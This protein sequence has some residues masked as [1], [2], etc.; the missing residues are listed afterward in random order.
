LNFKDFLNIANKMYNNKYKYIQPSTD[1]VYKNKDITIICPMH[2]EYKKRVNRH[3]AG[4]ACNECRINNDRVTTNQFI[5]KAEQIH[6]DKYDYSLSEY[7]LS[8]IPLKIICKKHGVFEQTPNDHLS[9]RGC[10]I[11]GRI[12]VADTKRT[13]KE[14]FVQ[15]SRKAHGDK[16]SYSKTKYINMRTK[17]TITCPVHGDFEQIPSEHLTSSGCYKCSVMKRT[18]TTEQFIEKAKNVHGNK[19]KYDNVKYMGSN[20]PIRITCPVHG[21]FEQLPRIHL[22]NIGCMRCYRD[23]ERYINMKKFITASKKVHGS[24]YDYSKVNYINSKIPVTIICPI[25]GEFK[26]TPNS[27]IRGNCLKCAII[28]N[29]LST[30]QFIEKARK[31]HGNKYDYNKTMYTLSKNIVVIT[32]PKHGDFEQTATSHLTGNG[33]SQCSISKGEEKIL[34]YLKK[35][36]ISHIREYK[37]PGYNY[38]YD[39]YLP[40]LNILIEYDG[41]QHFKPRSFFGGKDEFKKTR[42]RDKEKNTLAT[43]NNIHLI[44]IPYIKYNILEEYLEKQIK[45]FYKFN[46]KGTYYKT[47]LDMCRDLNLPGNTTIHNYKKFI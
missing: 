12:S 29:T 2:G 36:N 10:I 5:K 31:I 24:M 11:C 17:I 34:K 21:D 30:D 43:F 20:T 45:R 33:C 28:K 18:F 42:K 40:E 26:Q 13:T 19:Y 14:E 8:R 41:I 32:C 25:H 22:S 27:H 37:I 15:K 6:G 46:V 7:V 47:F 35:H 38:R 9:G 23:N 1:R 16:Y 44:R 39:F 4:S 3:L